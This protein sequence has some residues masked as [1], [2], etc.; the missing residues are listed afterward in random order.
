MVGSQVD[1][2]R[3]YGKFD[4]QNILKRT[5]GI[6][7]CCGKKLN[8]K[9]MTVEHVIPIMRGGYDSERNTIALCK[10]CNQMKGNMLYI[11]SWFYSAIMDKPLSRELTDMFIEWFQSV[12]QDF[13]IGLYPLIAPKHNLLLCLTEKGKSPFVRSNIIQWHYTGKQ[14]MQEVEEVTGVNLRE[15][16]DY[17]SDL[18]PSRDNRKAPVALY[19][20]RKLTT[21]K[22]LCLAA[23]SFNLE[24]KMAAICLKWSELPK[25][26][27]PT[28]YFS[29]MRLLSEVLII[30]K[31]DIKDI[32]F[33]AP[34][35]DIPAVQMMQAREIDTLT[36]GHGRTGQ[37]KVIIMTDTAT[38]DKYAG[39]KISVHEKG[40]IH[41]PIEKFN[42]VQQQ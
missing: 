13:D 10:E 38:G 12:K 32:L 18:M 24:E 37:S 6:C 28:I 31:Y 29:I 1:E 3:W 2:R 14:Y 9:T 16:R 39:L 36:I 8:L 30:T 17:V 23:V 4:K 5:G 34:E 15:L 33:L 25:H 7:A 19:T 20:C 11:P 42:M 41:L 27:R 35:E 21:D 40:E 26:Y 22:I